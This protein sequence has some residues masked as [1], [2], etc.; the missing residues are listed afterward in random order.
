[1]ALDNQ[2][3]DYIGCLRVL[4]LLSL[5]LLSRSR[6]RHTSKLVAEGLLKFDFAAKTEVIARLLAALAWYIIAIAL[7]EGVELGVCG[8]LVGG[9]LH[10]CLVQ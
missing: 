1:M 9:A 2:G 4:H 3:R 8:H 5:C 10:T 6:V 7:V